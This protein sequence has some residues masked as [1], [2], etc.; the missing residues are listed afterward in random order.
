VFLK[1]GEIINNRYRIVNQLGRG[2]FGA[3]YRAEDLSLQIPCALKVN[4]EVDQDTQRQFERE[5]LILAGLQHQNLPRVIDYF[6]LED[7]GQ[8]LVMDFIEGYDL[9]TV[10]QR[11]NQPLVEQQVLRWIDQICDALI[12]LH[13]QYP[14]II[15]RDIKPA[16]IKITSSGK[17]VL[18]DFGIAKRYDPNT[19]TT[20]GAQAVTPGYSPIEQYSQGK[21]DIKADL[22]ALGATVYTLLT[23]HKPPESI[24]RITGTALPAPRTLNASIS[25]HVEQ[26]ILRAMELLAPRRFRNIGDFQAALRT[27]TKNETNDAKK[28]ETIKFST[29]EMLASSEG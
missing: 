5:A 10:I 3:V 20:L 4:L 25:P 19:N 24:S 23:G 15:H 28:D 1:P 16:N 11:I 2:G 29:R 13:S 7:Q 6:T 9:Q 27:P 22:Y 17:A 8:F 26:A 18:V 14:P 21:T 12:Y